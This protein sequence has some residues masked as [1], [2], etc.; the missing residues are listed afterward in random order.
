MIGFDAA[1]GWTS[2]GGLGRGVAGEGRLDE[3]GVSAVLDSFW[4]IRV[5]QWRRG[6]SASMLL[7]GGAGDGAG[8][9]HTLVMILPQIRRVRSKLRI[10]G[11]FINAW[12]LPNI[13]MYRQERIAAGCGCEACNPEELGDPRPS[14]ES[15]ERKQ[16]RL[17][18][19]VFLAMLVVWW[20]DTNGR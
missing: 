6:D 17:E 13:A 4:A 10:S 7:L 12:A 2:G 3:W 15:N 5:R 1:G 9:K 16:L 20:T 11:C 8:P 18:L 19:G 14:S